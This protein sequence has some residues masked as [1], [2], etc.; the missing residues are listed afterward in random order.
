MLNDLEY[1]IYKSILQVSPS[2][3]SKLAKE[4]NIERATLYKVLETLEN[5]KLIRK[6]GRNSTGI[7]YL[8]QPTDKAKQELAN[9]KK[10]S[11]KDYEELVAKIESLKAFDKTA[12]VDEDPTMMCFRGKDALNQLDT[13]VIA[14]N[15]PLYGLTYDYN[16][17]SC[18]KFNTQGKLLKNTYLDLVLQV[19][20][21]FIFPGTPEK[22]KEMQAF[23]KSNPILEGKWQPR[24]IDKQDFN[25]KI[26]LYIFDDKIAFSYGGHKGTDFVTYIVANPLIY[27]SMQSV[28]EH[29]WKQA[30]A[31]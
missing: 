20:D 14:A 26:N 21:R 18:F 7:K 19:G 8:A 29:M 17:N 27:L 28:F 30:K 1:T 11:D 15:K 24:Y 16:L 3:I 22:V 25:F 5:K 13:M 9:L 12:L 10:N 6:A 31:I 23:L 2:N 4:H